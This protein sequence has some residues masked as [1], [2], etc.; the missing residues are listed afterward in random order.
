[1]LVEIGKLYLSVSRGLV[2]DILTL[3]KKAWDKI[4]RKTASPYF[5]YKKYAQLFDLFC[6]KLPKAAAVLDFG[7]GPG[8]PFT[9]ELVKNGFVVTAIDISSEMIKAAKNNVPN[10]RYVNISMTNIDFK[11][12]FDGIFSGFT[13]LCLDPK[14]FKIAAKKA[15][16]SLKSGGFFFLALNEPGPDGHGETE[17]ITEIMGQKMYSRPYSENEIRRV[18]SKLKMNVVKVVRETVTSQAY[19]VEHTLLV[20]L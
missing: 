14:N 3:N 16:Q 20:L 7:C 12:K 13:M 6:K 11:N 1:M 2:M 9:R 18:F 15:V 10:A 19:G 5:R 4:G 8:V 17:S